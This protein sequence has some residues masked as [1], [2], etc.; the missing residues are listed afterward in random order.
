MSVEIVFLLLLVIR[1][2]EFKKV[3]EQDIQEQ[4]KETN[5]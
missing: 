4:F 5:H 1:N 2:W 3:L